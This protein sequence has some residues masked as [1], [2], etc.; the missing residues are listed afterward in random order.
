MFQYLH[1]QFKKPRLTWNV[2][3]AY[4]FVSL[5]SEVPGILTYHSSAT[6]YEKTLTT[7][8]SHHS[9]VRILIV[10]KK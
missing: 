7:D 6:C 4:N 1:I 8:T 2:F 10:I 5:G 3:R 9:I